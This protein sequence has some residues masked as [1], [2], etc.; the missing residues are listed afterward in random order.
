MRHGPTVS[1]L[2]PPLRRIITV[3]AA[4]MTA[5]TIKSCNAL[6]ALG[7]VECIFLRFLCDFS[8]RD[9]VSG[10]RER[11]KVCENSASGA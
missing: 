10:T 2:P 4:T 3:A 6:Q 7:Y 1:L 8:V 11:G 9:C 5:T